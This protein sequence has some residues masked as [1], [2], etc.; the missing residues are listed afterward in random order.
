MFQLSS[1]QMYCVGVH[2]VHVLPRPL[3]QKSLAEKQA[4]Y[5]TIEHAKSQ[6][7]AE[8]QVTIVSVTFMHMQPVIMSAW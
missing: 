1:N 6:S 8:L 4:E 5:V 2:A 3:S 7:E